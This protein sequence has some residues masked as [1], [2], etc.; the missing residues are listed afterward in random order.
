[1]SKA[2]AAQLVKAAETQ[3]LKVAIAVVVKGSDVLLVCRREDSEDISWQFPAGIVK[4]RATAATIA[5]RETLAETGIHCKVERYLGSRVHPITN[6][7]CDYFLCSYLTGEAQ[8]RDPEENI[9]VTWTP[10]SQLAN[11]IP[12][13]RIYPPIL[14]ALEEQQ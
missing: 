9:N 6:V 3:A 5:V 4:P 11:F 8:N 14:K 10:I 12:L 1:M 2:R 13:D 7:L